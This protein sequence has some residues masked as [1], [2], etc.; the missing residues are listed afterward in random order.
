MYPKRQYSRTG[1]ARYSH[2]QSKLRR[3]LGPVVPVRFVCRFGSC[4]GSVRP[5]LVRCG[6]VFHL[7]RQPRAR[8][9]GCCC[10]PPSID[11]AKSLSGH[12]TRDPRGGN[13]PVFSA[14]TVF[15]AVSAVS[16]DFDSVRPRD[17]KRGAAV[18]STRHRHH[19]KPLCRRGMNEGSVAPGGDGAGAVVV[20]TRPQPRHD[21]WVVLFIS[22]R[23]VG[24][25]LFRREELVRY[26][27]G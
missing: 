9:P 23:R 20:H 14:S 16:C 26:C 18:V 8:C 6:F 2:K 3:L 5:G 27:F 25:A 19:V 22:S 24:L 10:T 17:G 11:A 7:F 13:P 15:S 21:V 1:P 4:A 12:E